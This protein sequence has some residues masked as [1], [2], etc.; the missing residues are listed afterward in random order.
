MNCANKM[1]LH[2]MLLSFI[3]ASFSCNKRLESYSTPV[4]YTAF[5]YTLKKNSKF[6][7]GY[8]GC[9]SRTVGSGTYRISDDSLILDFGDHTI[10][11]G[12]YELNKTKERSDSILLNVYAEDADNNMSIIQ[13]KLNIKSDNKLNETILGD[14]D[15]FSNFSCEYT[16]QKLDVNISYGQD[17]IFD[18]EIVEPGEYSIIVHLVNLGVSIRRDEEVIYKIYEFDKEKLVLGYFNEEEEENE[19]ESKITLYRKK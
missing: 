7:Y 17:Y 11:R 2:L 1:K 13:Y 15:G 19:E 6:S 12:S 9:T 8:S 10:P 3:M 4:N 16:K 5:G 14:L 18:M